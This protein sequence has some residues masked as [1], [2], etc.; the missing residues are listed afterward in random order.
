MAKTRRELL[1][2]LRNQLQI[3]GG[4][5]DLAKQDDPY[6][7]KARLEM[8]SVYETMRHLAKAMEEY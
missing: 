1:H 6:I 4:F 7:R 3:V 2:D 5:L 8:R